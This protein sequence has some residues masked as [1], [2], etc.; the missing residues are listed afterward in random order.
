[1]AIN[2]ATLKVETVIV[3]VR[4]HTFLRSPA[5]EYLQCHYVSDLQPAIDVQRVSCKFITC[6]VELIT[7]AAAD[8]LRVAW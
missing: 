8:S 3:A 1:V 5:S 2:T 6:L 7:Q 4:L